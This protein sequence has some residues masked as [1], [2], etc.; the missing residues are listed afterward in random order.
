[1]DHGQAGAVR[2]VEV[3]GER[4]LDAVRGPI[5]LLATRDDAVERE[6]G[7]PHRVATGLIT[8]R[9]ATAGA[10]G[11]QDMPLDGLG[12]LVGEIVVAG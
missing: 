2:D 7:I 8:A 6:R 5:L 12:H 4:M 11:A 1:M 3:G 9:M 10:P